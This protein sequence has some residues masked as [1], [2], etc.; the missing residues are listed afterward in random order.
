MNM[1][2]MTEE[3]TALK[4]VVPTKFVVASCSFW[5]TAMRTFAKHLPKNHKKDHLYKNIWSVEAVKA[6]KRCF[7]L[8][9]VNLSQ[10]NP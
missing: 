7:V 2:L 10:I 9:T 5:A 4:S 1:Q 3:T 8:G 6:F